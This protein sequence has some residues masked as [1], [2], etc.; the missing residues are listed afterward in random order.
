MPANVRSRKTEIYILAQVASPKL[1]P[2]V[3]VLLHLHHTL[4]ATGHKP[5][6]KMPFRVICHK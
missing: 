5:Q 3:P 1:Q 2:W 6:D 4:A